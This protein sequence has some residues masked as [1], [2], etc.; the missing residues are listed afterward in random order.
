MELITMIQKYFIYVLCILFLFISSFNTCA[1]ED[2][3]YFGKR[4]QETDVIMVGDDSICLF[5]KFGQTSTN[6]SI[7]LESPLFIYPLIDHSNT[8]KQAGT[9]SSFT[10]KIN[11]DAAPGKYNISV[12]ISYYIETGIFINKNIF[13]LISY[14]KAIEI[15][16]IDI[17]QVTERI[18]SIDIETYVN[19]DEIRVVFDPDGDIDAEP[20]EII[21]YDLSPGRHTLETRIFRKSVSITNGNRTIDYD[22]YATSKG[23]TIH[24]SNNDIELAINW[25]NDERKIGDF[26]IYLLIIILI[27]ILMV[28]NYLWYFKK[29]GRSNGTKPF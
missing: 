7:A 21:L 25:E 23:E 20:E 16:D 22:I 26:L 9:T 17:P 15:I 1:E 13:I 10:L 4:F 2:D 24:I 18:F 8:T 27:I 3:I 5:I 29:I 28:F 12:N 11:P 14:I 6:Y 19:F